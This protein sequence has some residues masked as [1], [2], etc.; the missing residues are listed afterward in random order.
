MSRGLFRSDLYY[1]LNTHSVQLPA[2]R[3]RPNDLQLLL[4]HFIDQACCSFGKPSIECHPST[5]ELLRG[6]HF[7]GNIR[8]LK[9]MVDDTVA[10]HESGKLTQDDFLKKMPLPKSKSEIP[11]A[12]YQKKEWDESMKDWNTLP[13]FDAVKNLLIKE[14]LRRSGNNRSVA[15]KLI[16]TTRQALGQ[17]IKR[18]L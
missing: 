18:H 17:W 15:A 16:G 5:L 11:K 13:T 7:P 12:Y 3:N 4:A 14:S 6:Y 8:E 2:L 1:R 10:R 9:A